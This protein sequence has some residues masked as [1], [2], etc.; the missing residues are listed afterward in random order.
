MRTLMHVGLVL[1][2]AACGG[3]APATPDA[4]PADCRQ[5]LGVFNGMLDANLYTWRSGGP[6]T[7]VLQNAPNRLEIDYPNHR[8]AMGQANG[9]RMIDLDDPSGGM[10]VA[11][12]GDVNVWQWTTDGVLV[13]GGELLAVF[14]PSD[15]QFHPLVDPEAGVDWTMAIASPD[16]ARVL[17]LRAA[18][19]GGPGVLYSID[20]ATRVATLYPGDLT[21]LPRAW[22]PDGRHVALSG[23]RGLLEAVLVL[24]LTTGTMQQIHSDVEI[25]EVLWS[26]TGDRL[27]VGGK[28]G[29]E[30]AL[31]TMN[32]DGSAP[33][34][35]SAKHYPFSAFW[36]PDGT[37]VSWVTGEYQD[38][39]PGT[40]TIGDP[41]GVARADVPVPFPA[42][43]LVPLHFWILGR[44]T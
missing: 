24:D 34:R 39:F 26:P 28:G 15:N 37:E 9:L 23:T 41:M 32:P 16:G 14:R 30:S 33:S 1:T 10:L 29:G 31:L 27:L 11:R 40:M 20:V 22:S 3:D 21:D 43:G 44:C 38:R 4:L 19:G 2:F 25:D 12:D 8:A 42:I 17:A 13:T 36:S 6:A 7:G 18:S 5:M 35:L